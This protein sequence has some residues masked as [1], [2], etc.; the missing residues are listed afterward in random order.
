LKTY[1]ANGLCKG[2]V[3]K[4]IVTISTKVID[5]PIGRV[6]QQMQQPSIATMDI[7]NIMNTKILKEQGNLRGHT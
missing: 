6:F 4:Q 5:A 1:L 7:N 2:V 3:A